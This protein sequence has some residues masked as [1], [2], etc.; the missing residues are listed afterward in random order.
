MGHQPSVAL[1]N[2][3]AF[4]QKVDP[5]FHVLPLGFTHL[6]PG[7]VR[8]MRQITI[9]DTDEI[10]LAEREIEMEIHEP[11]E[12]V[13]DVGRPRHDRPRTGQ[14]PGA[15]ADQQFDEQRLFVR[16]VP[17]DGWA[18]DASGGS[19]VLQPHRE[20]PALGDEAL[21]SCEQLRPSVGL[22]PAAAGLGGGCGGHF[23]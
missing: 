6:T 3:V 19:D 8:E 17:V 9:L 13:A 7:P 12:R 18:A 4:A 10:R 23:G 16:E 5:H 15:D 22:E 11:V 20:I 14:Q 1:V 21:G 2:A